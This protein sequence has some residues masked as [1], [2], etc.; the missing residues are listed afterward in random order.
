MAIKKCLKC[1]KKKLT[2]EYGKHPSNEDGYQIWCYTCQAKYQRNVYQKHAEDKKTQVSARRERLGR[3]LDRVKAQNSCQCG[4]D[5]PM[6]LSLYAMVEGVSKVSKNSGIDKIR[7]ALNGSAVICLN[8]RVK[9]DA[10]LQPPPA[11]PLQWNPAELEPLENATVEPKEKKEPKRPALPPGVQEPGS[12]GK[13]SPT[14]S[15]DS[16]PQ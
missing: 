16:M 5:E 3:L 4:E 7:A 6:C 13:K 1:N 2:S 14:D 10:G 15:T 9:V 11:E 8:C 12:P